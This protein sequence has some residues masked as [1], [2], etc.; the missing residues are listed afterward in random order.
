MVADPLQV[1]GEYIEAWVLDMFL[2]MFYGSGVVVDGT[3]AA[4]H[5]HEIGMEEIPSSDMNRYGLPVCHLPEAGKSGRRKHPFIKC[6]YPT[7]FPGGSLKIPFAL[8][9]SHQVYAVGC[10]SF[11]ISAVGFVV[12]LNPFPDFTGEKQMFQ[13]RPEHGSLQQAGEPHAFV[14]VFYVEQ[15]LQFVAAMIPMLEYFVFIEEYPPLPAFFQGC[16][17]RILE[18]LVPEPAG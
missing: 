5:L 3:D 12:V 7:H 10:A 8:P 4:E 9:V 6:E 2:Y 17:E 18:H 15:V 16:I 11:R 14:V 13:D 1:V